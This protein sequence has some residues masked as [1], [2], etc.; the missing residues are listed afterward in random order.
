MIKDSSIV[1][2]DRRKETA[3][4]RQFI[5]MMILSIASHQSFGTCFRRDKSWSV[6]AFDLCTKLKQPKQYPSSSSWKSITVDIGTKPSSS[7][8]LTQVPVQNLRKTRY[9]IDD[10]VCPPTNLLML[11]SVVRKA[12]RSLPRYLHYKPIATHTRQAFDSLL[13]QLLIDLV[14]GNHH[15]DDVEYSIPELILS[16]FSSGIILDSGCGTGRSTRLLAEM[17]P[18]HLILGIDRSITRLTK[19]KNNQKKQGDDDDDNQIYIHPIAPN[20]YL[21]RAELVDFWRCCLD[22]DSNF[23]TNHISH[24]YLLYPNPYP[25]LQRLTLRWYAHPS[26]PLLLQLN[27]QQLI[28]RSN[29]EGYLKEFSMAVEIASDYYNARHETPPL[30]FWS[31]TRSTSKCRSNN[32]PALPYMA[33]ARC[34]PHEHHVQSVPWTNFEAKYDKVGERTFELTLCRW[35]EIS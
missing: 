7:L 16:K 2:R 8:D 4:R 31:S 23:W 14:R 9:T 22:H 18:R 28:V 29:W 20:A 6:K 3:H 27:A 21:I 12:C 10:S 35:K 15:D 19:S 5:L 13:Q 11:E 24:H 34:G 30:P 17:Y 25:T 32:N 1:I 33:S 26:F